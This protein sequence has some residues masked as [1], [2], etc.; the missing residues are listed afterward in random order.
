MRYLYLTFL[1]VTLAAISPHSSA[2]SRPFDRYTP[3]EKSAKPKQHSAA[4][5]F[6]DGERLM[7]NGEH[8]K[9]AKVFKKIVKKYPDNPVAVTAQF[10]VGEAFFKL[11]KYKKAFQ[12]YQKLIDSHPG[13]S[14]LKDALKRQFEIAEIYYNN[15]PKKLP[16]VPVSIPA[17]RR[18]A[19]EFYEK[20][21]ANAP[22]SSFSQISRYHIARVYND[23]NK[24]DEAIAAYQRFIDHSPG[25]E[26]VPDALYRSGRCYEEKAFGTRYDEVSLK[27]A[28]GIFNNYLKRFPRGERSD[29]VKQTLKRL[30]EKQAREN[31]EIGLFYEKQLKHKSAKIYYQTVLDNHPNSV[32]AKNA[33]NRLQKLES[34]DKKQVN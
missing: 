24:Y 5:F 28:V 16:V 32:W 6:E 10:N 18:P 9:A 20:I 14:G 27:K 17:N 31:Y 4:T 19:I 33:R 2:R 29:E 15:K 8:K 12:A 11:R 26:H 25:N 30:Y 13:F 23:S 34:G 21:I 3:V 7:Q 1:V 22:F